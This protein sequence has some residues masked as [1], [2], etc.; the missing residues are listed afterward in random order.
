MF[1]N[2]RNKTAQGSSE[3]PLIFPIICSFSNVYI[4]E[5]SGKFI[6]V[7]AGLPWD[8]YKINHF[9]NEIAPRLDLIF[10]THAHPDHYGCATSIRDITKAPIAI[11]QKDESILKSGKIVLG[12]TRGFGSVAEYPLRG[13]SR[14]SNLPALIPD[15]TLE[16]GDTLE[17]LGIEA[18]IIHTPGHTP[19]S[20]TLYFPDGTAFV[21]DLASSNG[22]PHLQRYFAQ[23]WS[24]FRSSIQKI[25]KS[26]PKRI[27]PGHGKEMIQGDFLDQFV[28]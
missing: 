21:G 26:K 2:A 1:E 5:I 4:V 3:K 15:L 25:S 11:H 7:D 28:S 19:G 9:L 27:Y 6:L 13:F 24:V 22:T 8:R 12:E 10:L 17:F 14:I 20:S 18:E 23:D 16:D